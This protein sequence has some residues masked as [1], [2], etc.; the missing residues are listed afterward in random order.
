MRGKLE[1]ALDKMGP[2]VPQ[3]LDHFIKTTHLQ[4]YD[5]DDE[6]PRSK[7]DMPVR[8]Y[9]LVNNINGDLDFKRIKMRLKM[10]F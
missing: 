4:K 9:V 5:T 3:I 1:D 7:V 8:K 2:R 10:S 6:I